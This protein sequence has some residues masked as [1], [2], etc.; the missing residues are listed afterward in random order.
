M[1]ILI[2]GQERII[3]TVRCLRCSRVI[4]PM[5]A[6]ERTSTSCKFHPGPSKT[7]LRVYN[8]YDEVL[9][10]CCNRVQKGWCPVIEEAD[11]CAEAA[12]DFGDAVLPP[13]Q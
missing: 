8:A 3:K 13:L 10:L 11:T 2:V 4:D 9:Y 5:D 1:L 7:S 6:S 12:H